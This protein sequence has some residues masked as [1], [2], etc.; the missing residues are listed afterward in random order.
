MAFA[1]LVLEERGDGC[2]PGT[3]IQQL[4]DQLQNQL[5]AALQLG[6]PRGVNWRAVVLCQGS[7]PFSVRCMVLRLLLDQCELIEVE[8]RPGRFE[9]QNV[10]VRRLLELEEVDEAELGCGTPQVC[11]PDAIVVKQR[12]LLQQTILQA[13]ENPEPLILR[14]SLL[15]DG[16]QFGRRVQAAIEPINALQVFQHRNDVDIL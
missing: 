6:L 4:L 1:F 14:V 12:W 10:L 16:L 15:D 9:I 11:Q 3:L 7:T 8:V 2:M 5:R 13:L